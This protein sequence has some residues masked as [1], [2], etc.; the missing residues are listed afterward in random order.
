MRRNTDKIPRRLTRDFLILLYVFNISTRTCLPHF[1]I[2]AIV[3]LK[4]RFPHNNG[5]NFIFMNYE[6]AIASAL[7]YASF[8]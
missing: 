5:R 3:Y 2:S 7:A 6:I 8:Q 1:K 4:D